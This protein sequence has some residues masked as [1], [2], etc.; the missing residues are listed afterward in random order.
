MILIPSWT[1]SL[2]SLQLCGHHWETM[3]LCSLRMDFKL[4]T[5]Q[6]SA[7]W[8]SAYSMRQKSVRFLRQ[9]K[10]A[11]VSSQLSQRETTTWPASPAEPASQL[12]EALAPAARRISLLCDWCFVQSETRLCKRQDA[13]KQLNEMKCSPCGRA[14]RRP[15]S[16]VVVR[17]RQVARERLASWR[18][19]PL[20]GQV[21][22]GDGSSLSRGVSV[23][24]RTGHSKSPVEDRAQDMGLEDNLLSLHERP[25]EPRNWFFPWLRN[26]KNVSMD[27]FCP[28][29][30]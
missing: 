23:L 19:D 28:P 30:D 22:G 9:A 12:G 21:R 6:T 26:G 4:P 14:R 24:W 7:R 16:V 11:T 2:I 17:S 29:P 8:F 25:L 27:L 13:Q 18:R 20:V 15:D 5:N 3:K 1:A 10:A